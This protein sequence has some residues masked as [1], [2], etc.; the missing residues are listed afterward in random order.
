MFTSYVI[1]EMQMNITMK[2]HYTPIKM[3]ESRMLTTAN[4]SKDVE[5]HSLLVGLQNG[6]AALE[7]SLVVS[8]NAKHTLILP[9][10]SHVLLY[11]PKG[12]ENLYP[13]R[14][15]HMDVY[16]IFIH[17]CQNMEAMRMS[18]TR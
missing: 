5:Y 7:D 6:I 16:S 17:N 11:L 1:R 14:K 12:V 15:I 18:F 8:Y 10:S 4:A 9:S 3:A 2:Y 13:H